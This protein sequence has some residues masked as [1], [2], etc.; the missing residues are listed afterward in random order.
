MGTRGNE[1]KHFI[2]NLKKRFTK[3]IILALAII[4]G[5]SLFESCNKLNGDSVQ[6]TIIQTI[7]RTN[8]SNMSLD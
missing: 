2:V 6:Q 1:M 3:K 4:I 7:A 5:L 8:L